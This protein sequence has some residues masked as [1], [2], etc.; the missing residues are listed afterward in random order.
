MSLADKD[1]HLCTCNGTMPLDAERL[2]AEA[3]LDEWLKD[4]A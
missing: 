2:A 1:L 3:E 4:N